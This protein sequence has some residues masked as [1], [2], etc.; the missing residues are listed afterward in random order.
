MIPFYKP[1]LRRK[2]MDAVLQTM[3]DERIGPG[4]RKS[5]FL[6][7]FCDLLEAKG[8][9]ALRSYPDALLGSLQTAGLVEGDKVGVSV[10]SPALYAA[11][12]QKLGIELVFG[13]IDAEHGCLSQS[14]A[15][16]LVNAE[17][18]K[19]LLVH[20]PICQIPLG[21]DY[22]GLGA[23]VIEDIT[24]SLES[25]YEEVKAGSWGDLIVCA[26][27]E[28]G[29]VST[30]GGAIL[31][32]R[33]DT[34]KG[35]CSSLFEGSR[36]YVEMPDMNAAL[37]IIQLATLIEQVGRRR[38]LYTTFSKALMKT[39]HRLLGIGGIDFMPNG[40]GFCTVLDS[41]AEEAIKFATKYKVMAKR[42]FADSLA[43]GVEEI[44][45]HYPSATAPF[46]RAITLPIYPFLK[47]SDV[48]LLLKVISHLP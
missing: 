27:E 13:D 6:Q 32:Y 24:Q 19:A 11:V 37:G 36:Q 44:F 47:Q 4:E 1:T 25:S 43:Q 3:V 46:L 31:A 30:G 16:R 21:C 33:E 17:G 45:D 12:A 28:D 40:Y 7:Q 22:K 23:P 26:F 41:K 29:V 9:I 39:H 42:T 34:Y 35:R 38:E 5:E 10:L 20:E 8:G 14:E 18:C 48:E 2:D 15:E